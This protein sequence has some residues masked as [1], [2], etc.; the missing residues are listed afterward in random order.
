MGGWDQKLFKVKIWLEVIIILFDW[1]CFI[2][3]SDDVLNFDM[4]LSLEILY[5]CFVFV[6]KCIMLSMYFVYVYFCDQVEVYYG[7]LDYLY[8]VVLFYFK[9]FN[10]CSF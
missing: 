1:F 6:E 7:M 2:R 4:K 5:V 10:G 9:D 8:R 3:V